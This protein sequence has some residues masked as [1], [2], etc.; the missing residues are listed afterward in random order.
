MVLSA[1]EANHVCTTSSASAYLVQL[2]ILS[3]HHSK[4]EMILR[5]INFDQMSSKIIRT[6]VSHIL[7]GMSGGGSNTLLRNCQ[8]GFALKAAYFCHGQSNNSNENCSFRWFSFSNDMLNTKNVLKVVSAEVK[9]WQW[10]ST[11]VILD[12]IS[13]SC[14]KF[15]II[16]NG[17]SIAALKAIHVLFFFA[18][19]A[20]QSFCRERW[21]GE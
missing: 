13:M 7:N 2:E 21:R 4:I 12:L 19:F 14:Q 1:Q 11:Q 17:Y 6:H 5:K 10:H 18:G 3:Q 9:P 20:A 8:A 15:G 16:W